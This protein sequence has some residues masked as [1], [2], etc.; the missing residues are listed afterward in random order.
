MQS[1]T[2]E[3][4]RAIHIRVGAPMTKTERAL[5]LDLK[6][7]LK[8]RAWPVLRKLED[9]T[10]PLKGRLSIGALRNATDASLPENRVLIEGAV[11]G[12][13]GLD[14]QTELAFRALWDDLS[15][16]LDEFHDTFQIS[17]SAEIRRL[18][19]HGYV[20]DVFDIDKIVALLL[21]MILELENG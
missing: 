19:P 17:G 4:S 18:A 9:L 21:R 6:A 14:P 12:L 13:G 1:S 20:E 10:A 3:M 11:S 15:L 5:F 8:R 2:V 16:L 7:G